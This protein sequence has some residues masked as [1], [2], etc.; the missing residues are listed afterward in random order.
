MSEEWWTY[1]QAAAWCGVKPATYRAYIVQQDAPKGTRFDP[2]T[3][4][5]LVAAG[6]VRAWWAGRPGQG[7]RTDLRSRG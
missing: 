6:L 3:G 5:R 4:R 7:A 1:D 2:D